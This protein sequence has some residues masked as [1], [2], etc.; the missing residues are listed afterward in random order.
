MTYCP[1]C[2]AR[3]ETAWKFCTACG[4]DLAPV[5]EP[6]VAKVESK[7]P[8]TPAVNKS[9][10][11]PWVGA[12]VLVA[13]LWWLSGFFHFANSEDGMRVV[14]KI[15][16]SPSET[17]VSVDAI[18]SMPYVAAKARW[19]LA[20]AA[21]ARDGIIESDS[22]FKARVERETQEKIDQAMG[23]DPVME[24]FMRERYGSK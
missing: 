6:V 24:E 22:A 15:H 1:K 17:F 12:I 18:T 9:R 4:A 3:L 19:P 13:G 10:R 5:P 21:L 11:F 23:R 2:G 14:P 20:C 7:E 16:W 8:E